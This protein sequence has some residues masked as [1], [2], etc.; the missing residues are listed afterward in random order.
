M[1]RA[2]NL[3]TMK[4]NAGIPIR[5]AYDLSGAGGGVTR[6]LALPDW[7]GRAFEV[8]DVWLVSKDTTAANVTVKNKTTA[9]T[10][11]IAK[12]TSA[13]AVVRATSLIVASTKILGLNDLKCTI[14]A[15]ADIKLF[16][17]GVLHLR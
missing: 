13:N 1:I 10:N 17:D 5:L 7:S 3:A 9:I 12:G 15:A 16:I 4:D 2:Y 14:S 8:A 6:D 11:A